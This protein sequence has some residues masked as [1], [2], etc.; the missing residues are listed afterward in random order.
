M[1]KYNFEE[2][3]KRNLLIYNYLRGS[4]CHGI[5]TPLSDEDYCGIYLAP[6][7]QILGL[8]LDYQDQISN[9]TNDIVWYELQKFMNLLL[10]SNP[11][12]LEALFVD[13]KYV[14]YEHPIM[15]EIKKHKEKFLTK[16]CFDSFFSYA[17][18]QIKKAR[19]LNKKINWEVPERKGILDFV[20][21]YHKQG[22]SK[23]QNW[24]EYR[25]LKQKY[26]GLVNVPNMH[27][28]YS[29]FYDWGNHFLNENVTFDDLK[30]A[31]LDDNVYDTINIVKRLKNGE[32]NLTLLKKL[33]KAQF[34]NM[35]NFI[36]ETYGLDDYHGLTGLASL[37]YWFNLQKPIGYKGMTNEAETSNELRLSS[38][39]QWVLPICHISYNKDGYSSHCRV[40]KE[41]QDWIKHRN[42]VRY[43]SNLKKSYDAK[44]MCEC[45]RLINCGI[46]I[47][48]GEGYKVDRSNIDADFLLDVKNHKYEYNELMEMLEKKN[49]EMEKAMAESTT[50]E[51]IDVEFVNDLLLK[52][53]KEQL[54]L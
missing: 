47:A 4:H 1:K 20:Y 23:I 18:S 45:F 52:I 50:P 8:G 11:T 35:V 14:E 28:N 46:E 39:E 31:Y 13:D 21:T 53:R 5:S 34:K 15:T 42:P 19:G 10:K 2:I 44:N 40:W 33:R 38:V 36:V 7:E 41:Y 3:K 51:K 54:G 49:D 12:V 48:R 25:N 29:V 9:E 37:E 27:D 6:V 22:S 30:E 32:K 17:K 43:E 24:L 16:K 26:C